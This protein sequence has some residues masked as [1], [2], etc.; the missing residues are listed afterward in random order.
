MRRKKL[1]G[2]GPL[3][4]SESQC[5]AFDVEISFIHMQI[6]VPLH[7]NKLISIWKALH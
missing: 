2:S 6:L 7:V 5:E 3:F 4:Q 1:E